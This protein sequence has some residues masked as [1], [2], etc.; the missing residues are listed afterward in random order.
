MKADTDE[1]MPATNTSAPYTTPPTART[2]FS[3]HTVPPASATGLLRK[4]RDMVLE[5]LLRLV[6]HALDKADD[7][8][9]ELADKAQNDAQQRV[10]FDAMRDIRLRR[11]GLETAVKAHFLDRFDRRPGPTSSSQDRAGTEGPGKTLGLVD[12]DELEVSIA[13]QGMVTKALAECDDELYPLNRRVGYLLGE[14]ELESA[15]NPVGPEVLCLTLREASETL[16]TTLAIR[17]LVLKLFDRHVSGALG[18]LYHGLNQHLAAQ[19]VLPKVARPSQGRPAVRTSRGGNATGQPA[20]PAVALDPEVM[21]LIQE[22]AAVTR[23]GQTVSFAGAGTGYGTALS[24]LTAIQ[25]GQAVMAPGFALDPAM[26]GVGTVNVLRELR[27][28][29]FTREMSQVDDLIL[30]VVTLLF[31]YILDDKSVPTA[32]KA[33]IGRLQ[34]PMLKVAILDKALFAHKTHPARRLLNMLAEAAVGWD[35]GRDG[36]DDLFRAI[37]RVV[38]RVLTEFDQNVE[39]FAQLAEELEA[40][41][42]SQ[43]QRAIQRAEV[44]AKI[45]Q[46]RE[47]LEQAKAAADSEVHR[48]LAMP[49][50]PP[51][52]REFLD[53]HWRN[54]L[55]VTHNREGHASQLW[56]SRVEAMDTLAWSVTPKRTPSERRELLAVLPAFVRALNEAIQSLGLA[57]DERERFL[58]MLSRCHAAALKGESVAGPAGAP[59]AEPDT[60]VEPG[61]EGVPVAAASSGEALPAGVD[62][63]A[64]FEEIV[65][66]ANADETVVEVAPP[67]QPEHDAHL[68]VA[69][70]LALGTWVEFLGENGGRTRAR[71][72]WVSSVTGVYLFTDRRG[73]KVAERTPAG[74]A[75]DFRR[76]SARVLEAVPLFDRAV[77]QLMKGLRRAPAVPH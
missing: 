42:A 2:S 75:A 38:Q 5:S 40:F 43:E 46:G 22:L 73:M 37:E 56:R 32:L 41:L 44:T 69:Q 72:T 3:A 24:A 60:L 7:A 49:E 6:G 33:L 48:V 13:V 18:E 70:N 67:P 39:L 29:G 17:L 10:Y 66:E 8:L 20:A 23:P 11:A 4:L 52:V 19:G 16:G 25:N 15:R 55:V 21:S 36:N 57:D 31:D 76:G 68:E 58:G 47:R 34:I 45:L 1:P 9:F 74:L 12:N 63:E 64:E 59:P 26:V 27:A 30:E 35:E 28:S 71:L 14:P 54:L 51:G 62:P 53:R 50:V 61:P 77:S 65:I